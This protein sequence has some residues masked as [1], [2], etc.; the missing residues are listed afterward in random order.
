[1]KMTLSIGARVIVRGGFG[2][3]PPREVIVEDIG[4]KNNRPLFSYTLDGV[5]R[6][7][8]FSQI[9]RIISEK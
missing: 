6:W 4:E 2:D 7:A 3:E 9:D 5:S 8:Y 1:M